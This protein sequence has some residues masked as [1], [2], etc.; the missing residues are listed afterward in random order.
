LQG[1]YVA[2]LVSGTPRIALATCSYF[3]DGDPDDAGLPDAIAGSAFV[4]WDDDRVDWDAYDLVV[5]RSTWDYQGR[6]DEYLAWARRVGDRLVN[7]P[8]VVAWNTDK[9]YLRELAAAGLA[10]VETALVA[11]GEAFVAPE[12]E[13]GGDGEYVVKPTVSAGSRD[14]ARFTGDDPR[15]HALVDAIHKSGRTAMVQP[16][17]PSVDERGET[18]LL[19]FGGAFS[20]AIHKGPLLARGADPTSEVFAAETIEPREATEAE[21]ALGERVLAWVGER[22][23]GAELTYARVDVVEG[24]DGAP[25]VLELELTEPSL[26]FMGESA[27]LAPFAEAVGRAAAGAAAAR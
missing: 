27:R 17:V 14:T 4:V 13:A 9:K 10:V 26:F 23:P 12:A 25:L 20:H 5:I 22:F 2:E 18:A 11:P 15:A 19:F 8:E 16:Y 21:R 24:P 6:R 3:P 7:P 1:V